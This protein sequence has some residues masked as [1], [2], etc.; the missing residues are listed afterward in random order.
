MK[1]LDQMIV[2]AFPTLQGLFLHTLFSLPLYF[3]FSSSP[4]LKASTIT[5]SGEPKHLQLSSR[6]Q[7]SSFHQDVHVLHL[8]HTTTY[9]KQNT[10]SSSPS[11]LSRAGIEQCGSLAHF[12]KEENFKCYITSFSF[13][14]CS[15]ACPLQ[16]LDHISHVVSESGDLQYQELEFV[17]L[18]LVLLFAIIQPLQT[19]L[20]MPVQA[21]HPPLHLDCC[22]RA[23]KTP[24]LKPAY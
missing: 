5:P 10:A 7:S 15:S 20:I 4:T 12:P 1:A 14:L 21:R 2:K 8:T 17:S 6:A 23:H 22:S 13:C 19:C 9:P 3:T 18:T 16:S 24:Q 11:A